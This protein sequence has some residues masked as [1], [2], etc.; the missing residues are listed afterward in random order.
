MVFCA[1]LTAKIVG[2]YD[3]V[4]GGWPFI[5]GIF[6]NGTFH[7]GASIINKHWILTAAHCTH[8]Y[9]KYV[10]EAQA[11]MTRR[12][13]QIYILLADDKAIIITSLVCEF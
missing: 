8:G 4:H 7:C 3:S 2:G 5:V 9:E 6:R 1:G 10:F 13:F 12:Y 11:G